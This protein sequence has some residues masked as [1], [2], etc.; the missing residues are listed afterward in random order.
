MACLNLYS[1]LL[2]LIYIGAYS[3]FYCFFNENPVLKEDK[4][5]EK[6]KK[7][8]KKKENLQT[9]PESRNKYPALALVKAFVLITHIEERSD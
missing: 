4:I 1:P 6:S 8:K 2:H 3:V 7:K 9:L 5:E